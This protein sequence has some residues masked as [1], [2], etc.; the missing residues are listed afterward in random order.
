M[1]YTHSE[2]AAT[3]ER[4]LPQLRV[5]VVDDDEFNLAFVRGALPSPPLEVTTAINGRA[6]VDAIR[7]V[8][9]GGV[10]LDLGVAVWGGLGGPT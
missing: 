8:A 6:A 5:L 4:P 2:G 1:A 3:Y 9:P 7:A 10:F